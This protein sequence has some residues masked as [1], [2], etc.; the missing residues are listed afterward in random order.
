MNE[1]KSSL[2]IW[3]Q[4]LVNVHLPRWHELPELEL[5]M[6]QVITLVER[7]LSPVILKEKHTL[8]TSSMV[9]NYVKLGLIPAPHKKRYNQK[10]LAFLI[11]ITLLKQVLTIPEIKQGILYQGAA[12]GIREAYNLFCDE[13][14]AA[15]AVVVAQALGTEPVAAFDQPIPVEFLIVKG[16]T[17]SFATKLFTEKAIELAQTNSKEDGEKLDE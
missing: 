9:N 11:A 8:L 10:H 16:A 17:L 1:L 6:D 15:I 13:Q 4:E 5:Y 14:E 2:E 12:V 3:G 7:Y